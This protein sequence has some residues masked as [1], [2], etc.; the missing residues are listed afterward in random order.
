MGILKAEFPNAKV[1]FCQF[2][3]IKCFFKKVCD[4]EVPKDNRD[5]VWNVLRQLVHAGDEST[6]DTLK[7]ELFELVNS[8]F[9]AYFLKNW[10]AC[11]R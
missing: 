11:H 3:I 5:A 7:E 9:K 8:D 6:Y 10:D 4:F 1:L 2:H